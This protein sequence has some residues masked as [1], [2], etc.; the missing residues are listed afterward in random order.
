[1][2]E[3]FAGFVA[4][5]PGLVV[6][7][8]VLLLVL[9]A[10]IALV[11]ERYV[12]YSER[13]WLPSSAESV[14]ASRVL[15]AFWGGGGSTV[16][17]AVVSSRSFDLG[18]AAAVEEVVERFARGYGVGV[19]VVGPAGVA[20][21][22]AGGL[23]FV[24]E[25]A[26][27]AVDGVVEGFYSVA[28]AASKAYKRAREGA[29]VAWALVQGYLALLERAREVYD[30]AR[31]AASM[32]TRCYSYLSRSLVEL[33]RVYA[34]VLSTMKM[35]H[36]VAWL[37]APY[38]STQ[39]SYTP[40][41]PEAAIE[42]LLQ[43][44]AGMGEATPTSVYGLGIGV[45]ELAKI[46]KYVEELGPCPGETEFRNATKNLIVSLVEEKYGAPT[47]RLAK[48][49]L[50]LIDAFGGPGLEPAKTRAAIDYVSTK[51]LEKMLARYG[52]STPPPRVEDIAQLLSGE[53]GEENLTAILVR[54]MVA[55]HVREVGGT[56]AEK[57]VDVILAGRDPVVELIIEK[58]GLV[59]PASAS[60]R[61]A[62]YRALTELGVP[63]WMAKLALKTSNQKEFVNR[64]LEQTLETFL[65]ELRRRV[66]EKSY[67]L[68]ANLAE[69]VF[70]ERGEI[71]KTM[72]ATV[73]AK[74]VFETVKPIVRV[75]EEAYGVRVQALQILEQAALA[76]VNGEEEELDKLLAGVKHGVE[77][78]V[79]SSLKDQMVSGDGT[80]VL[81][82]VRFEAEDEATIYNTT[83]FLVEKLRGEGYNCYAMG[84]AYEGLETR[85]SVSQDISRVD[86]LSAVMVL[87]VLLAVMRALAA[88]ILPF[89][90]IG[91]SVLLGTAIVALFAMHGASITSWARSMMMATALGLGID[92]TAYVVTRVREELAR[93]GDPRDAIRRGLAA[94]ITG[95]AGS[96]TTDFL[97]F[98]S[99]LLA[100]DM[101]FLKSLGIVLPPVVLAVALAS[102]TLVPA[103][104]AFVAEKKWFWWP[105]PIRARRARTPTLAR[106]SVS[107]PSLV[108]ITLALLAVPAAYNLATF[109]G[110]YDLRLFMPEDS[111]IVKGLTVLEE[112]LTPGKLFPVNIVVVLKSRHGLA[113][114][115]K[116]SE[117]LIGNITREVNATVYGPTRPHGRP[118][119]PQTILEAGKV[120]LELA[121][122][123]IRNTTSSTIFTVR[124]ELHVNPLSSEGLKL[125]AKV[126]HAAHRWAERE[127]ETVEEVLVGGVPATIHELNAIMSREFLLRVLPAATL[128]MALSMYAV[129]RTLSAALLSL[130]SIALGVSYAMLVA[131][132]VFNKLA[133]VGLLWFLPAV[134][135]VV[136][137]GVGMDYNSF[138]INRL[139]EE[140][141]RVKPREAALAAS[142]ATTRLVLGLSL[143]VS[144]SYS[145]MIF[146]RSW[147]LRELGASLALAIVFTSLIAVVALWPSTTTLMGDKTWWPRRMRRGAYVWELGRGV[148]V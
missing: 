7:L 97:G 22:V 45:R 124:V 76:V 27:R 12:S 103:I 142:T 19:S 13:E 33:D 65:E 16:F 102:V 128:S 80:V 126:H 70:E 61:Q 43:A 11:L 111:G 138:Y 136:A 66:D 35:L 41:T 101:P 74:R 123:Y 14:R 113:K 109:T 81:L 57:L 120:G 134:V 110:S 15:G 84:G 104:L 139:L 87:V 119:S 90:A 64:V 121:S 42:E 10:P 85:K 137:L 30:G 98:A 4:G 54:T 46:L 20:G 145:A 148:R 92:Y 18:S 127:A 94:S 36:R 38:N 143:I 100:W 44:I 25:G 78:Q 122:Q 108:L 118:V 69:K 53:G 59:E 28:L 86:K 117:S 112:K 31:S 21:L 40:P 133:G 3:R 77:E 29:T 37:F 147:G 8:W 132:L 88:S 2:S 52:L 99:F 5:R 58:R 135:A 107:K 73:A 68:L 24:L 83:L 144:S 62:L 71:N 75:F 146:T 17:L 47:A 50:D 9:S 51:L 115:L 106:L 63:D 91:A 60:A 131:T 141:S 93:G 116:L 23:G 89:F 79:F 55:S 72:V 105:R 26:L 6:V 67:L 129:F 48:A 32:L 140:A 82:I 56:A 130:A 39:T 96:A 34:T 114:V 1:M 125:V 95:V 49:L